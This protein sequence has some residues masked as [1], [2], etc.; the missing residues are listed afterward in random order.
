VTPSVV[1]AAAAS[2]KKTNARRS[3]PVESSTS[4]AT[5]A[6]SS[7]YCSRR[8]RS[9]VITS[10]DDKRSG[11]QCIAERAAEIGEC[12]GELHFDAFDGDLHDLRD[13]RIRELMLPAKNDDHASSLRQLRDRLTQAAAELRCLELGVG[14]RR[15]GRLANAEVDR[16]FRGSRDDALMA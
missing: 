8:S 4:S 12:S 14:A 16:V 5:R 2:D 9:M 7:W 3:T 13:L 10:S 11:N 6:R 15:R 1:A